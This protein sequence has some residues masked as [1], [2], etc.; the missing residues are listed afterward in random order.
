M[1]TNSIKT[2]LLLGLLTALILWIGDLVGGRGG[3]IVALILA[4]AMNGYSYWYSDRMVLN[5]TGAQE[6]R[7]EHAH[8]SQKPRTPLGRSGLFGLQSLP[9]NRSNDS[10]FRAEGPASVFDA[11][12]EPR[13]RCLLR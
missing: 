7:P 10:L 2:F 11:W 9:V 3:V 6:V 5:S 12:Q 13:H 1:S 8:L 4:L